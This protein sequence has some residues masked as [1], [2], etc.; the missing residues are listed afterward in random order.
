MAAI[1]SRPEWFHLDKLPWWKRTDRSEW[2][3]IRIN[4]NNPE[5][6]GTRMGL[7]SDLGYL[8]ASA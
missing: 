3:K 7:G 8:G 5:W 1:L 4:V 2:V 6:D